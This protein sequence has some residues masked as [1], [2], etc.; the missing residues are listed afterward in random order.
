MRYNC[1]C[2]Q[3][4]RTQNGM[5]RAVTSYMIPYFLVL[6]ILNRK[7]HHIHMDVRDVNTGR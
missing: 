4:A 7:H 2:M 5:N 6:I 3:Y 1:V